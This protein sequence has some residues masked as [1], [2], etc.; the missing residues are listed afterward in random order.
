M[1]TKLSQ[2]KQIAENQQVKKRLVLCAA[3][4]EHSLDAVYHAYK[5]GVIT[6][7]LVGNE[8]KIRKMMEEYGFFFIED[9]IR[10]V[11]ET[12]PNKMVETSIKLIR[13]G[14]G[15]ILM[16]GHITTAE[17]LRGVL[18]KE[19]GLKEK[20]V[21]SHFALFEIP[22]YHK[23][24]ALTD[25]A[26]NISPDLEAKMGIINNSVEFMGRIGVET[27]KIAAIAAVEMVNEKMSATTDAALL[28]IMNRRGQIRNCTIDGPLAFDNAIS[29]E[30]SEHKGIKGEVA[31][32][33]DLL[34]VPD[35]EA[36]NVLYKAFVFF[37]NAK[38]ASIILG[39]SVPVVLTSR[40]DSEETK[41]NSIRLAAAS[42]ADFEV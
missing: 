17:L 33:A 11:H 19:W 34:L 4:D 39:A 35:I 32:D 26:M 3:A 15:D 14:E 30:S 24:L 29:F 1:L 23:L 28:S 6:P 22:A 27:P 31:G 18:N 10:I 21:L 9:D 2:L 41:L 40:A 25:V 8:E 42:A 16:K 12:K 13:N 5:E 36:G 7:I 20:K 37:A 38:V